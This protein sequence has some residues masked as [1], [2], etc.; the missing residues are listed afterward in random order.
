MVL[1]S[2]RDIPMQEDWL[3]VPSLTGHQD[4]FISW[5]WVPDN[6][7]HLPLVKLVYVALLK[8]WPDFRVGMVFSILVLALIAAGFIMFIRHIRGRTRW[9]DAF[10]PVVFLS[11]GNW[12]VMGFSWEIQNVL[13]A[14]LA[15]GLLF[16][17]ASRGQWT[18]R[19]ALGLGGCLVGIPL[20]GG[21]AL[22][23]AP[24]VSLALIPR[25]RSLGR[26]PRAVVI[27]SV[28][29]SVTLT[30]AA[31]I[32]IP[33]SSG[34]P[35]SPSLWATLET[36]AKFLG[37][38]IGPAGGAWWFLSA[39][40][41]TTFLVGAVFSLLRARKEGTWILIAFML[42]GL[43]LALEVGNSRAG[44]VRYYGM[45]DRYAIIGV[46]ALC[47]AFLAYDRY[48]QGAWRRLGPGLLCA[49]VI[50]VLPLN[51]AFGLQYRDWYHQRY[52]TFASYVK[53]GVPASQLAYYGEI[54]AGNP[55][56]LTNLLRLH[57]AHIGVFSQLRVDEGNPSP[58][59]RIDGFDSGGAG[60]S[61]LGGPE[62]TGALVQ[63]GGQTVL[64]WSF[65]SSGGAARILGRSFPTP[66]DWRG[67]GAI[68]ITMQGQGSGRPLN[69]RVV[70]MSGAAQIDRFD[71]TFVD[72]Q[73]GSHTVVIP[74]NGFLHVNSEGGFDLQ[75]PMPLQRVV[76]VVFGASGQGR[77]SLVIERVAL[78]PGD[79]QLG[80][81]L[82]SQVSRSSLP[83]WR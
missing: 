22:P 77:G 27:C 61:A 57:Q 11:L 64:R 1:L 20:T 65:D 8:A 37:L 63:S 15:C 25:L 45:P 50:A 67:M 42:A 31:L 46:P 28:V 75:G 58:G 72:N 36:T 17:V 14:G 18:T 79:G 3:L 56:L 55:Y 71:T 53:K 10:F 34:A 74:W 41:V 32:G 23:F 66:Q 38:G 21:T 39:L 33:H 44:Q 49:A 35:P 26:G 2:A 62:S 60:W 70:T 24:L 54:S 16:A 12:E 7:H 29:V 4:H 68:A 81:P 76:A 30:I 47:C 13:A 80:W 78:E 69:L 51:V 19:R 82:S 6:E 5:L 40:G 59:L 43:I 48:S 52:D 83:P 73:T 9:V